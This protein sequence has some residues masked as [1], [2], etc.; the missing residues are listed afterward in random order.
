MKR[1]PPRFIVPAYVVVVAI[2]K[3]MLRKAGLGSLPL[4]MYSVDPKS[5]ANTKTIRK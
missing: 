2:R 5:E 4:H 1:S 3:V